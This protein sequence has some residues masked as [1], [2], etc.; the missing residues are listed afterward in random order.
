MLALYLISEGESAEAA[1][2]RVSPVEPVVVETARQILF[3]EQ[4]A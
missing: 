2:R 4:Y 1:I 3:L